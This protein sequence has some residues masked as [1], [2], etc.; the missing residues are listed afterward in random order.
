MVDELGSLLLECGS[1]RLG[2]DG[3]DPVF[4]RA[5]IV[6][7]RIVGGDRVRRRQELS[8]ERRSRLAVPVSLL[9][10]PIVHIGW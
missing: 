4:V 10:D 1:E 9:V 2:V 5:F 6:G 7:S 3:L 8:T